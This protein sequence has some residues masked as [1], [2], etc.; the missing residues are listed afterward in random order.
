MTEFALIL[1][2]LAMLLFAIIQ[3]G[4]V[5]H[6]YVR[7]PTPPAPAPARPR[8]AATCPIPPRRR[9]PPC[10]RPRAASTP[11]TSTCRSRR[12]S[13][14]GSDVT[15]TTSYPYS[16]SLLGLVVKSGRMTSKTTERV[17]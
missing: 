2:V 5:F 13:T 6:N 8:S 10:A 1:P 16:I 15:V 9:R 14:R 17:E 3:F 12:A 11:A 7:S 4:I